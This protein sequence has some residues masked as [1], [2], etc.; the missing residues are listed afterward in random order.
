MT[1]EFIGRLADES[2]AA[3]V[4]AGD[5]DYP[6]RMAGLHE[7]IGFDRLLVGHSPSSPDGLA[8]AGQVLTTTSALGVLL[9]HRPGVVAPTAAARQYATLDAFH[10]GRVAMHVVADGGPAGQERDGDFAGQAARQRR[11]GEFLDVVR[12][13]WDRA[14]PFDYAGEFYRVCGARSQVRPPGGSLPVYVDGAAPEAARH[15][16]VCLLGAKPADAVA[17]RIAAVS[18]VAAAHGRPLSFGVTV[19]PAVLTGGRDRVTGALLAYVAAGVST[20]VLPAR[21]PEPDAA[22]LTEIIAL[23]RAGA[24]DGRSRTCG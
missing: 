9:A 10:P 11:T 13:A 3:T 16:D 20:L 8:V 12:L 1:V 17:A 24:A 4:L 22:R 19:P 2:T 14:E 15:A 21:D 7:E 18:A 6:V 5:P 23:A